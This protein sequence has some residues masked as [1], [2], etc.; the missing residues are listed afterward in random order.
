MTLGMVLLPGPRRRRFLT[1][2]VPLY[3]HPSLSR[4]ACHTAA[5]GGG[6]NLKRVE[7]FRRQATAGIWP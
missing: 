1:S 6:G 4:D 7:D 5:E 3:N 2:E